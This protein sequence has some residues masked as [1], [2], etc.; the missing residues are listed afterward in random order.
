MFGGGWCWAEE[1][2][3]G[4]VYAAGLECGGGSMDGLEVVEACILE[5]E[6]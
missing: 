4:G 5:Y 3:A 2:E 1:I 6:A